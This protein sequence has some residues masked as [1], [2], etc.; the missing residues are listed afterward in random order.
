MIELKN[1]SKTYLSK[2]KKL[3]STAVRDISLVFEQTDG[4]VFIIGKSGSGKTTLLNLI[5]LLDTC[6]SGTISINGI[7]TSSLDKKGIDDLINSY[8]SFIFQDSNLLPDLTVI[9]NLHLVQKIRGKDD[10]IDL[11]SFG[12]AGFEDRYPHELS[13]GERQR[14]AIIRGLLGGK[15][16]FLCDEPTASL[17]YE[18][19][20]NVMNLLQKISKDHLVII[21]THNRNIIREYADRV[22]EIDAGKVTKDTRVHPKDKSLDD[23]KHIEEKPDSHLDK[24]EVIELAKS[25]RRFHKAV[26]VIF[27]ILLA[28]L[29]IVFAS[30]ISLATFNPYVVLENTMQDT[31]TN[32]YPYKPI[33]TEDEY[34]STVQGS[35][36]GNDVT[37]GYVETIFSPSEYGVY[38]IDDEG[39]KM[40]YEKD[41]TLAL[42]ETVMN[43]DL[44][45][46]IYDGDEFVSGKTFSFKGVNYNIVGICEEK[47]L[48]SSYANVD[49]FTTMEIA[50]GVFTSSMRAGMEEYLERDAVYA[51]FSSY[52]E[53]FPEISTLA[54]NEAIV[55][56][57]IYNGMTEYD[58][59]KTK[60]W[61]RSLKGLANEEYAANFIDLDSI[62]PNGVYIKDSLLDSYNYI[63]I[64]SDNK[65][66]EI[67]NLYLNYDGIYFNKDASKSHIAKFF[68]DYDYAFGDIERD[69]IIMIHKQVNYFS[70]YAIALITFIVFLILLMVFISSDNIIKSKKNEI[71]F[72]KSQGLGDQKS[73]LPS[74]T[75]AAA[76]I[77]IGFIS[78]L[79]LTP[80]AFWGLNNFFYKLSSVTFPFFSCTWQLPF[81]L[82]LLLIIEVGF[83]WLQCIKNTRKYSTVNIFKVVD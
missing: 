71:G 35:C 78:T 50:G 72:L 75:T 2:K 76:L 48:Y 5:G 4:M 73:V 41:S 22:V 61:Y 51:S 54:D 64:V 10:E 6:S 9:E 15:P 11:G 77:T 17:D 29:S 12:L 36:Y 59:S 44:Y 46:L 28:T 47:G 39:I 21:V 37:L 38:S 34:G 60:Q 16:I 65:Y 14:V 81:A 18:N 67:K 80:L 3:N 30:L 52:S 69:S 79:V 27:V 23:N 1:V 62:F 45:K 42:G 68:V 55:S 24:K 43:S 13:G 20:S 74:F 57:G 63:I 40:H 8:F 66:N 19:E 83:I 32:F 25:Y 70:S 26:P 58:R 49:V 33:K 7:D 53:T 82:L 31:Q 56:K